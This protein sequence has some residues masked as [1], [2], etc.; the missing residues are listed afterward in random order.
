MKIYAI[1]DR[2]SEQ[3]VNVFSSPSDESAKRSFKMLI[4]RDEGPNRNFF[5]LFRND[6]LL[7]PVA[8]LKMNGVVLNVCAQGSEVLQ[9]NGFRIDSY[10]VVNPIDNGSDYTDSDILLLSEKMK[11]I[12]GDSEN[13]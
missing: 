11:P 7:Y 8:E 9:K 13:E 6:F 1:V 5:N 3:V 4:S 10:D 12:K 2:R